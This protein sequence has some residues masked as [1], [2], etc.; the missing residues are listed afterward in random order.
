MISI[1][2]TIPLGYLSDTSQIPPRYLP[3]ISQKKRL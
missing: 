2:V 3:D 1:I